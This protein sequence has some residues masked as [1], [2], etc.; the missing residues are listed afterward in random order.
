MKMNV[1]LLTAGTGALLLCALAALLRQGRR[2]A[3]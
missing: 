2:A 3:P 1:L